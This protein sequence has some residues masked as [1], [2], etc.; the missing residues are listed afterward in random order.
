MLG[1]FTSKVI[2]PKIDV[3]FICSRCGK[4][5]PE[6]NDFVIFNTSKG[7]LTLCREHYEEFEE[8]RHAS[9]KEVESKYYELCMGKKLF[10][11]TLIA[12]LLMALSVFLGEMA[13]TE[14]K[15]QLKKRKLKK[16]ESVIVD[17]TLTDTKDNIDY[18]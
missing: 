8:L 15:S 13:K 10:C 2:E 11:S 14:V 18:V 5:E 16:S 17:Y 7:R 9:R 6:V 1:L 3:V 4:R 12:A